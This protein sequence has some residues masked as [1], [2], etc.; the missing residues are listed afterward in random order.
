L[1][2]RVEVAMGWE[3][4]AGKAASVAPLE[5]QVVVAVQEAA[6]GAAAAAVAEAAAA[7]E[8]EVAR[9]E[10]AAMARTARLYNWS[11]RRVSGSLR[12]RRR[13]RWQTCR[14]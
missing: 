4:A 11:A 6:P 13:A 3:V 12:S 5:A 8:V 14:L 9:R 2:A 7:M 10:A 1:E